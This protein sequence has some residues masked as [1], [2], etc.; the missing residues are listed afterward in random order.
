MHSLDISGNGDGTSTGIVFRK[1]QGNYFVHAEGR[2]LLCTISNQLR[3]RLVYP[4][5]ATTSIRPH[6]VAVEEIREVDPIAIGDLVRF[7]HAG[8]GSGMITEVLPRRRNL[9]RLD[10]GFKPLAQVIV[11]NLD[12]MVIVVAA[13]QP[14]PK[15]HLVDRYLAQAELEELPAMICITK[16][17]L[18]KPQ[19]LAEQVGIYQAIGYPVV[20]TCAK[21]GAGIEPLKAML[22]D[23]ISVLA[24]QSGVGKTTLLNT[25]QPGLGLRVSEISRATG[26]GVHT[27]SQL[28][29]FQ[30]A[31]GGSIVDTPGIK[32]FRLWD[33]E[34]MG[35]AY[36][37]PEMRPFLGRCQFRADCTHS[38]EPGCAVKRAVEDGSISTPRYSSYLKL[39]K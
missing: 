20:L 19:A 2:E 23:Q 39:R 3:K 5:A 31:S 21:T 36:L 35:L 4:I 33:A 22:K 29:M 6:V 27:T 26:K 37:F 17:D 25:I 24:G 14:A 15:W 34:K 32:Y 13:A 30:L 1:S 9:R 11:A 28:E 18:A 38:H 12:Q 8:K 7:V 10:P 16:L